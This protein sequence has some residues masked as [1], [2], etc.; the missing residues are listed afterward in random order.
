MTKNVK[1]TACFYYLAKNKSRIS[2]EINSLLRSF[3]QIQIYLNF[4]IK[5]YLIL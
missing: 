1:K 2:E 4:I 3:K 5:R